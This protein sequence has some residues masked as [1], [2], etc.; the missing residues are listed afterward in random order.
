LGGNQIVDVT[1]LILPEGLTWLYLAG[2]QISDVSCITK[3]SCPK[4]TVISLS[5]NPIPQAEADRLREELSGCHIELGDLLPAPEPESEFACSGGDLPKK[6]EG[7]PT[8]DSKGGIAD[9]GESSGH[10]IIVGLGPGG[11]PLSPVLTTR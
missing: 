11:P 6:D 1:C 4:A 2:N 3:S 9:K 5:R 10:A 8:A 7:G